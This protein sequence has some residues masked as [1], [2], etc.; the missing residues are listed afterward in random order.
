MIPKGIK[1]TIWLWR[2][3][4]TFLQ[5]QNTEV[6]SHCHVNHL[7]VYQFLKQI[8]SGHNIVQ[9][10]SLVAQ[11]PT[12]NMLLRIYGKQI[13][14]R[15]CAPFCVL[16]KVFWVSL[17]CTLMY[18]NVDYTLCVL[19][20]VFWVSLKCTEMLIILYVCLWKCFECLLSVHLYTEMLII[21][22]VCLWMC[23]ECLLSVHLYTEMLIILYVMS[24]LRL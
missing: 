9:L 8:N 19:V 5:T 14:Y 18:W 22:Y 4:S 12:T 21:L 11:S 16:V 15:I 10:T 6:L 17:K 1:S 23:F 7:K 20:K 24:C 2:W 13:V 3:G